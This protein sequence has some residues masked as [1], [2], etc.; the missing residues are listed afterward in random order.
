MLVAAFPEDVVVA[1]ATFLVA[2]TF[3]ASLTVVLGAVTVC[4]KDLVELVVALKSQIL[5]FSPSR[6]VPSCLLILVRKAQ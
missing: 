5:P 6:V 3:R 1:G 2:A 4:A